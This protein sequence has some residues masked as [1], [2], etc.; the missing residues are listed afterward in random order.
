MLEL[1]TPLSPD[2]VSH[3]RRLARERGERTAFVWLRDGQ[4]EERV[5]S[6]QE[7]DRRARTLAQELER[8]GLRGHRVLLFFS[9]GLEFIEAFL[10][11][12]YAGA[13]AVPL[14]SPRNAQGARTL[15]GIVEHADASLVL[16]DRVLLE[17]RLSSNELFGSL[18]VLSEH[19]VPRR[20]R[21]AWAP[22]TVDPDAL[23]F[24]QYTSGSTGRPKGVRVL[25]RN[26]MAN[27]AMIQHGFGHDQ[28]TVFC[29]WLPMFHDMGLVGN[30]LQPLYVGIPAILM[31]PLA[32]VQRPVRWLR[33]MSKYRATTT[34]SPN[35]GYELC[36][37]R[38]RDEHVRELD[39]SHCKIAYNG[40]EP[41]RARTLERFQERFAPAGFRAEAFFPCYGMAEATLFVSGGPPRERAKVFEVDADELAGDRFE[42]PDAR[43][44]RTRRVVSCGPVSI[45]Q[46]VCIVDPESL[47]TRGPGEVGEIWVQ[48][49]N[50]ADGYRNLPVGEEDP[51]RAR[52]ADGRG[53]FFRTGDLGC[54]V[55]G[56]L[57]VT[58][59]RKDVLIQA[60][61]NY[62]PQDVELAATGSHAALRIDHAAA[63][64]VEHEDQERL[65]VVAEVDRRRVR[66]LED[67][68]GALAAL[69]AELTAAIRAAISTHYDLHAW[70]VVLIRQASL[71]KT[72]SGK[73]RRRTCRELWRTGQLA[74]LSDAP[75]TVLG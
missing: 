37:D 5:L 56:E 70:Q 52:L 72:T 28:D 50:L 57:V 25:H 43:T 19:E 54:L 22:E 53:P 23:A 24:L 6:F 62:Y 73:V 49:P 41:V 33:A 45:D 21:Q 38:V 16:T 48:G 36:V 35:F 7:L 11:C 15:R 69:E 29:S 26:L 46:R 47:E 17:S 61:R 74:R 66:P 44:Q 64:T 20:A 3:T 34:G 75:Q 2:L 18:P 55:D 4:E 59:R 27:L 1:A 40:S 8:R 51:F 39:L 30:V 71:P 31:A 60:G 12:L 13:V 42:L 10:G 58:G 9:P 32:F 68:P 14:S 63:F 67:D 65:V